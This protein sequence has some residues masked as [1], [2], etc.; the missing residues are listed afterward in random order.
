LVDFNDEVPAIADYWACHQRE[1]K[2]Q[3]TIETDAPIPN[4]PS[5]SRTPTPFLPRILLR[6]TLVL[7]VVA[8]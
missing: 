2:H 5:R 8:G 3:T 7:L 4:R 1:N 6:E